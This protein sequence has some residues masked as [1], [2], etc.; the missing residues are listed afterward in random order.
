MPDA[1]Q[2]W[3]IFLERLMKTDHIAAQLYTLRD[4][5]KT[6]KEL[7]Q[8]LHRVRKIG[9]PAVQVS[10]IG[11]IDP[12][13]L[14]KLLKEEGLICCA[15]HTSLDRL[16]DNPET[17]IEEL[18]AWNCAF[19]AIGGYFPKD[20]TADLW[21]RFA[22]DFN[23]IAE[24]FKGSGIVLGYHNHSHELIKFDGKTAL[25]ILLDRLEPSIAFEL[26]T[27][28]ITHGGGD[29][30]A[31]IRRVEN[32]IPC[33]HLKDMGMCLPRE[34]IMMEVGEGN[35]NWPAILD[36]CKSA[37]VDWYIVEQDTCYRDPFDSL[38]TSLRNLRGM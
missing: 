2:I 29:P 13:E 23:Q 33:V 30:A 19:T 35:L 14:A 38:E 1:A 11:P 31:W 26:D 15:T 34:Q 20:A 12:H 32:R 9:Y 18:R 24:K 16:R 37:G 6:P 10:A 36:A 25:Q 21:N 3:P 17:V 5:T 4:F 22:D 28:W 27:Y 8:T 7:A